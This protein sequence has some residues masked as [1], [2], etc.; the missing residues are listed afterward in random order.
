MRKLPAIGIACL[1]LSACS[2]TV[3]ITESTDATDE[4]VVTAPATTRPK[5][6]PT[7]T[8]ASYSPEQEYLVNVKIFT[9]QTIYLTDAEL[10]EAGYLVCDGLDSGMTATEMAETLFNASYEYGQG[11]TQMF[12][13]MAASATNYL[14]PWNQSVWQE[15][16]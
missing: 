15:F 2:K 9:E 6:R 3:Y 5:P 4:S 1:A 10:L 8:Q 12:A 11:M 14:C 7:T 16:E 13:V